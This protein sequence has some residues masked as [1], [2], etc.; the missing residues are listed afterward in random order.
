MITTIR[1]SPVISACTLRSAALALFWMVS[2]DAGA[3][4]VAAATEAAARSGGGQ[5]PAF[6]W[7]P[8]PEILGFSQ[9]PGD[10]SAAALVTL[11][12]GNEM[13]SLAGVE[14][15]RTDRRFRARVV[16]WFSDRSLVAGLASDFILHGSDNGVHLR[17]RP[18]SEYL[19]RWES[20]F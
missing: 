12:R 1:T 9:V 20:R 11:P 2:Q 14:L 5:A 8:S 7:N 10:P 6:D 4:A 3:D 19:V 15:E 16:G 13:A 18:G 17:M